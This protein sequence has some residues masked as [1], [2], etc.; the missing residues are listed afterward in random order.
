MLFLAVRSTSSLNLFSL[1]PRVMAWDDNTWIVDL[2]PCLSYWQVKAKSEDITS[3]LTSILGEDAHCYYS[4]HPWRAILGLE[5]GK[6]LDVSWEV[7]WQEAKQ[8]VNIKSSLTLKEISKFK[9]D[10]LRMQRMISRLTV[11]TPKELITAH[12]TAIKTRFG[13]ILE[14]L[15]EWTFCPHD[16]LFF[17]TGF[18]WIGIKPEDPPQVLR[19]LE[20]P[21]HD[22]SHIKDLLLEDFDRLA[23][24]TTN[25]ALTIA[26][27]LTL[28]DLSTRSSLISFRHPHPLNRELGHHKTA[29]LQARYAY[30]DLS[31][32]EVCEFEAAFLITGWTLALTS[33][34]E[35]S[36]WNDLYFDDQDSTSP[37][38]LVE[39]ENS[40][41]V[42]LKTYHLSP[43]WTP[44]DS[45][46][47]AS[48]QQDASP[49]SPS[50]LITGKSRP[51]YL[52]Q[53]PTAITDTSQLKKAS[54]S[55]RSMR[56]W[57]AEPSEDTVRDYYHVIDKKNRHL[58]T[59]RQQSGAWFIQGLFG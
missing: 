2:T 35:V 43:D 32:H 12:P 53:K 54:F 17:S 45:Y 24:L 14:E 22:W 18:P 46:T 4:N 16:N 47:Q 33:S 8:Y 59:Y 51:L 9:N 10:L 30:E 44:E 34:L 50:L 49:I 3:Y 11:R 38:S 40:V 7:W 26:W 13:T 42:P 28:Y 19:H 25:K 36:P 27:T 48:N 58:W 6:P 37:G 56:K 15:W 20:N 39:I 5:S 41:K 52:Y 57:W 21:V 23:Q 1:S 31:R 29:L 55:E